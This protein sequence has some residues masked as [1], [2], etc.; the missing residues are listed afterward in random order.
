MRGARVELS[1]ANEFV[2]RLHRHHK[3][4][5]GHRFSVGVEHAGKLVG[6]AICGRPVARKTDSRLVLE[7]TRCCTDGTPNACSYLYGKAAR[8]ASELGF[9]KIQTF[10]LAEE[11]TGA[12]LHAAGWL[13]GHTTAGGSWNKGQRA[14]KRR[15]DQP[16]GE[17]TLWYKNLRPG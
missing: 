7:V 12:S 3:P 10:I 5:R 17:K 1:D 2:S 9:T 15:D 16:E 8:L 13:K 11:E 14:G 4:V 6:V